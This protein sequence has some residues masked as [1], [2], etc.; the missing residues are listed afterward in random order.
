MISLLVNIILV[1][2]A[3]SNFTK[4]SSYI[5]SVQKIIEYRIEYKQNEQKHLKTHFK[6]ILTKKKIELPEWKKEIGNM[7]CEK[8]WDC[9]TAKA[10]FY[11]ESG[12]NCDAVSRTNDHGLAQ[13]HGIKEYD[14]R[15]NLDIAYEMYK[16]RGWQPWSAYKNRK[17]LQYLSI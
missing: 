11:A 6:T 16:K 9:K 1:L 5:N 17:Y 13:L 14:C 2:S 12:F 15:K 8:D 7:I 4:I 3:P 10:V